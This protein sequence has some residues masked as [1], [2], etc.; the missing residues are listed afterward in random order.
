[1]SLHVTLDVEL[2]SFDTKLYAP[3]L[4]L[5]AVSNEQAEMLHSRVEGYMQR[6]I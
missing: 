5:M 4:C 6:K 3:I 2:R 1:M